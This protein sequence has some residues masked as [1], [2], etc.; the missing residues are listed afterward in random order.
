[1]LGFKIWWFEFRVQFHNFSMSFHALINDT[2]S[3]RIIY[4]D[5]FMDW[6]SNDLN[7]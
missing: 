7:E 6:S 1:M 2:F 5:F 3:L 4:L